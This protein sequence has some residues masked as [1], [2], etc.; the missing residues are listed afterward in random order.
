MGG[1]PFR[2]SYVHSSNPAL[3]PWGTE[4]HNDLAAAAIE[5]ERL[6]A[7]LELAETVKFRR[8]RKLIRDVLS[9]SARRAAYRRTCGETARCIVR[10]H[11][12]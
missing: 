6:A 8:A 9:E 3:R 1:A 2:Q 11:G 7:A 12:R 5:A 4:L 10:K